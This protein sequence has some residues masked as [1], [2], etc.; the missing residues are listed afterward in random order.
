MGPSPC[1]PPSPD[2][3]SSSQPPRCCLEQPQGPMTLRG[4]RPSAFSQVLPHTHPELLE[5]PG[6]QCHFVPSP[7]GRGPQH[8]LCQHFSLYFQ[9]LLGCLMRLG[10]GW[11]TMNAARVTQMLYDPGG[12]GPPWAVVSPCTEGSAGWRCCWDFP[13]DGL[14]RNKSPLCD[15]GR[16][17]H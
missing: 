14:S 3:C 13:H 9:M 5:V 7:A 8:L 1:P 16:P 15:W 11:A 4:P 2:G 10:P 12:P 17:G 6:V